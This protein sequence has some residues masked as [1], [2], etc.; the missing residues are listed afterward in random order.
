M[1]VAQSLSL[2]VIGPLLTL[3][4]ITAMLGVLLNLF[5]GLSR[6]LLGL[7]RRGDVPGF[8]SRI[9]PVTQSPVTAVWITCVIIGLLVLSGDVV[10]TWSFSAFTVLIYYSI[11][12]LSALFLPANLRLYPRIMPVLGL[13][14]SLFLAFWIDPVILLIGAGVIGAGLVWHWVVR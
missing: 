13:F 3:T 7:S 5:L 1:I 2:P 10:F 9:N 8:I 4:A 6:V 12:N 11:T 14:G